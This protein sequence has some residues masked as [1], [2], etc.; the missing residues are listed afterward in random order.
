[1]S[2]TKRGNLP[3]RKRI[4][5][6]KLLQR[7]QICNHKRLLREECRPHVAQKRRELKNRIREWSK[8]TRGRFCVQT[9]W[10]KQHI[11]E[12]RRKQKLTGALQREKIREQRL[13]QRENIT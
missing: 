6:A 10:A 4:L 9:R 5:D 7:E 1:M 11:R 12:Q 8:L 13:G 3:P 2:R